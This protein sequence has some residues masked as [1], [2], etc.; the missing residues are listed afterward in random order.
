MFGLPRGAEGDQNSGPSQRGGGGC[1]ER[2]NEEGASR[3]AVSS[4]RCMLV[5]FSRG[6][7]IHTISLPPGAFFFVIFFCHPF[8][9]RGW[10]LFS[11]SPHLP[12]TRLHF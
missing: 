3:P 1:V 5:F 6:M 12:G 9:D 4:L 11:S 2:C 10:R 8:A 7:N